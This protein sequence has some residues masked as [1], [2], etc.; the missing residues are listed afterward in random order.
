[1]NYKEKRN[2]V[3]ALIESTLIGEIDQRQL[4]TQVVTDK[5]MAEDFNQSFYKGIGQTSSDKLLKVIEFDIISLTKAFLRNTTAIVFAVLNIVFASSKSKKES[6][7]GWTYG[8]PSQYFSTLVNLEK[9]RDFLDQKITSQ[10]IQPP[11]QYLIQSSSV[12]N[13]KGTDRIQVVRHVGLA[14]LKSA[15]SGKSKLL[16][17][18]L[19]RTS[20]WISMSFR[21]PILWRVGL[22][23][24]IDLQ[25]IDIRRSA[26]DLLVTTQT[27]LLNP[28]IAF[29]SSVE[30]QKI[31]FW[32]SDNGRQIL[33]RDSSEADYSYLARAEIDLHFVWTN[34]WAS[35]LAAQNKSAEVV[36]IGPIIFSN[37]DV[38]ESNPSQNLKRSGRIL[39]F[40][41]TPKKIAD[42][43]SIYSEEIMKDFIKDIIEVCEER[44]VGLNLH[45][46]PKR[47]YSK[48]DSKRYIS[49]LSESDGK[50]TTLKWDCDSQSEIESS[51]LVIC[52]PFTSPALIS[53]FLGVPCIFYSPI[54]GFVFERDYEGILVIQGKHELAAWFSQNDDKETF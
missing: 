6:S 46:K 32:Y 1:V 54:N 22:E 45:L 24:V 34:S 28:P 19:A 33:G 5:I 7:I 47:K 3:L 10:G 17:V 35:I 25:A 11:L 48:H 27:H 20:K 13:L 40:D 41:V 8:V 23:Y 15:N 38:R 37:L 30:W 14:I 43:K 42:D 21:N 51:E 52:I 39:I 50:I 12:T 29:Q 16:L 36:A 9:L 26:K 4:L 2:H 53:K 31:M 18:T 49:Y 44:Q